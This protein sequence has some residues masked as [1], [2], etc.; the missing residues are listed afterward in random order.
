MNQRLYLPLRPVMQLLHVGLQAK[1]NFTEIE[2][3]SHQRLVFS[4]NQ[5]DFQYDQRHLKLDA[6]LVAVCGMTYI[7]A[8]LISRFL[9]GVVHYDE[10][11]AQVAIL[12][13][14]EERPRDFSVAPPITGT[15]LNVDRFSA[16]QTISVLVDDRVR[17]FPL[18]AGIPMT[19]EDL[20]AATRQRATLEDLHVGDVVSMSFCANGSVAA[21]A[22]SYRSRNGQI[23]ALTGT[24]LALADGHISALGRD[25]TVSLNGKSTVLSTLRVGD[26][27]TVRSNPETLEVREVL[28][29]RPVKPSGMQRV[30]IEQLTLSPNRPLKAKEELMVFL[31]G[32]AHGHA[33][34]DLGVTAVDV[35]MV[36]ITPGLYRGSYVI[37]R[38]A[39]FLQSPVIGYLTLNGESAMPRSAETFFSAATLPPQVIDVAPNENQ[40]VNDPRAVIY[41]TFATPTGLGVEPKSIRLFINGQDVSLKASRTASYVSYQPLEDLRP[42]VVAINLDFSDR[43]G[44]K[45]SYHWSF[46][47]ESMER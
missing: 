42:G 23:A 33:H 9:G 15:L 11:S 30:V 1:G 21:L 40:T 27:V 6:P 24:T 25:A 37:V 20:V 44:N 36:E 5:A 31:R 12:V 47:Y 2:L 39:S 28:A 16:P 18:H 38:G 46:T 8:Q 22:D 13:H 35:P 29:S 32:T 10:H 34:F 45:M 41:A 19:I 4:T 7:P 43:A 14:L 17:I 26:R 3:P